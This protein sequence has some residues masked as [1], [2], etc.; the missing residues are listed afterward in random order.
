M[1][2][3]SGDHGDSK[4]K[5][6]RR[7]VKDFKKDKKTTITIELELKS[8][9]QVSL[10]SEKIRNTMKIP[11]HSFYLQSFLAQWFSLVLVLLSSFCL[12]QVLAF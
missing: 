5:D 1:G 7:C 10:H 3:K 11:R 12:G 8:T 9:Q 6:D 2:R 4:K